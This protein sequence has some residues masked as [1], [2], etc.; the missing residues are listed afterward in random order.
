MA[1]TEVYSWRLSPDM[2]AALE[3]A[4]R[5]EK[6]N[7]SKLLERIV[8]KWL[9]EPR[10]G[11][12]DDGADQRRLHRAARCAIG[13]IR[14]GKPSRSANIRRDVRARLAKRRRAG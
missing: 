5:E 11:G 14:G 8:K 12:G 10:S 3:E 13:R 6:E 2:K 7:V 9:T 4:A 1:K